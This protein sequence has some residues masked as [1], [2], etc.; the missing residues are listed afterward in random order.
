M[1]KTVSLTLAFILILF[2]IIFGALSMLAPKFLATVFDNMG[3]Y[4]TSIM[5]YER[6]YN[7]TNSLADLVV[8]L[9]KVDV[10]KSSSVAEKY[11][12][13]MINSEDFSTYC[14]LYDDGESLIPLEYYYYGIHAQ[15]LFLNSKTDEAISFC[16]QWV[17]GYSEFNP[18]R[19]V[20]STIATKISS[21]QLTAI[22]S[23]IEGLIGGLTGERL[24]FA[25]L[26][27]FYINNLIQ[28]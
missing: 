12:R 4:A 2:G 27:L 24:A 25:Q 6:Q 26:D 10:E 21:E 13:I 14:L 23:S 15:S 28:G 1:V 19:I 3:D 5:S 7:E 17:N 22:K 16:S 18:Y 20:V 11:S 9:D 8:L